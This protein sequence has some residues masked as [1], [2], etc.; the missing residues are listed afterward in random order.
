MSRK[1]RLTNEAVGHIAI[2]SDYIA[3]DSPRNAKRWRESLRERLRS[4]AHFSD[5]HEIAYGVGEVGRDVRHTFFGVYRILYTVEADTVV[6]LSVRHGA[7]KPLT[8][9]EVRRLGE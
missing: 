2:I 9:D 7:R 4:L 1:V 3:Q 6:V 5:R 8:P